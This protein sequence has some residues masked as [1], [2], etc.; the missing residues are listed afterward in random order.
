MTNKNKKGFSYLEVL[1]AGAL[2]SA[3]L[4][5][6]AMASYS[7]VQSHRAAYSNFNRTILAENLLTELINIAAFVDNPEMLNQDFIPDFETRYKTHLFEYTIEIVR[8]HTEDLNTDTLG[9]FSFEEFVITIEI[10]DIYTEA[11]TVAM[12]TFTGI[13]K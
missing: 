1:I 10:R 3:M 4:V 6:L 12:R 13:I 7:I 11:L 2:L 5:S 9:A 8:S